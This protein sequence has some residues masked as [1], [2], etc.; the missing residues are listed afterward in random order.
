LSVM[1]KFLFDARWWIV[2]AVYLDAEI[3]GCLA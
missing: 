2:A 3:G 1:M